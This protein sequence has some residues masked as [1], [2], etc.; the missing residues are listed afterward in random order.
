MIDITNEEL[1]HLKEEKYDINS[2]FISFLKEFND[3]FNND[4]IDDENKIYN[5]YINK[6]NEIEN[7]KG[8]IPNYY[9][10]YL[11]QNKKMKLL[12]NIFDEILKIKIL[13]ILII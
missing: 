4:E 5:I 9:Y 10:F 11:L 12:K 13:L 7:K 2:D 6:V 3:I 8:K 1:K